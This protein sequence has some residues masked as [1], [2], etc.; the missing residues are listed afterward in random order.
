[1]RLKEA[2]V[3]KLT[4]TQLNL[5]RGFDVIGDIALMEIPPEL[6]KK[7]GVIAKTLMG[8]LPSI[9]VVAKKKG[10]H[11]GMYRKQ[12][13]EVIGGEKR[14]TT[15]HREHGVSFALNIETCYFSPRLSTERIRIAKQVKPGENVLVLFSGVAPFPLVIAKHSKAAKVIGIEANPSAHKYAVENVKR[16]KLGDRVIVKKGDAKKAIPKMNFNRILL[17]WPQR[18]D[19]F[20]AS[21]LKHAKKGT[22]LHFYD[23]QPEGELHV[24]ADIVKAACKDAKKKCKILNIVEC[25][26]V[27]VRMKRVC[28]DFRIV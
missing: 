4:P 28:I 15:V 17:P 12:P 26:N 9:K 13:V 19:E 27:G 1:M 10:G 11:K 5:L 2:L 8:L 21:T 24:A 14:K 22:T 6:V 20:L 7:Q 25:G 18:A 3:G 23:F 16:N